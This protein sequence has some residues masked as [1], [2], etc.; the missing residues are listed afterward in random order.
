MRASIYRLPKTMENVLNAMKL[1]IRQL[2]QKFVGELNRSKW[3]YVV[4][5]LDCI[6]STSAS[7]FSLFLFKII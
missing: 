4:R 2:L 1:E 7:T 3:F 5:L 6:W